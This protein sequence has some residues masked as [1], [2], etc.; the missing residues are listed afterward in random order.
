MH[1]QGHS[2]DR[3]RIQLEDWG[4]ALCV[5]WPIANCE[6]YQQHLTSDSTRYF[7]RIVD[8]DLEN[9]TRSTN[10]TNLPRH[11]AIGL[12]C[13]TKGRCWLLNMIGKLENTR[14]FPL[15]R[16]AEITVGIETGHPPAQFPLGTPR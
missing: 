6:Q 14:N 8:M 16:F 12:R 15:I 11:I 7:I 4:R 9:C 1:L 2:V 5:V 10:L 3:I 13:E